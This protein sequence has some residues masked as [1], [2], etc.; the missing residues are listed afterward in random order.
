L[1]LNSI[2]DIFQ[3]LKSAPLDRVNI[4]GGD[5]FK[6]SQWAPL[7]EFICNSSKDRETCLYVHYLNLSAQEEKSAPFPISD[8]SVSMKVLVP[9]P[10]DK[11]KWIQFMRT[12]PTA[13]LETAEFLFPLAD[14]LQLAEAEEMITRFQIPNYT[15]HPFYNGENEDFFQQSVFLDKEDVQEA[16]PGTTEILARQLVNPFHFGRL[17][18]LSNGAVHANV[19]TPALGN[20][21]QSSLYPAIYKEMLHGKSWRRTRKNVKPCKQ[22]TYNALCPPLSNYEYALNKNN[23]C[24]ILNRNLWGSVDVMH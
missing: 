13:R 12:M 22:C 10:V 17:T 18:I 2:S 14:D 6:Y 15:F 7:T 21:K 9:L 11:Q 8:S 20:I 24:H 1:D 16:G 23:L 5:I 3:Q 4:L 19:N